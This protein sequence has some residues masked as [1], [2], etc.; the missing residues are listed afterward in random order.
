[1][2]ITFRRSGFRSVVATD[3]AQPTLTGA[4]STIVQG[5]DVARYEAGSVSS[6]VRSGTSVS[7]DFTAKDQFGNT[8]DAYNGVAHITS[9]DS[10]A[11][12][13]GDVTFVGGEALGVH[14]TLNTTGMQTITATDTMNPSVTATT[15]P[16]RVLAANY[17]IV[18]FPASV[19]AGET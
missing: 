19:I 6:P 16:A 14:V 12:L 11:V 13:P 18:G 10:Q 9:S 3:V 1:V 15:A 17:V 7:V 8:A 2:P 5:G 4:G